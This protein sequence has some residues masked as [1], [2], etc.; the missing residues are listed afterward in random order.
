MNCPCCHEPVGN[1][2][3]DVGPWVDELDLGGHIIGATRSV[4]IACGVCGVTE[5]FQDHH[6]RIRSAHGPFHNPKDVRR[7]ERRI[8]AMRHV[9][10]VPA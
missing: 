7:L 9:R 5:A 10:R 4:A 3:Y 6:R 2:Q 8:P 1:D